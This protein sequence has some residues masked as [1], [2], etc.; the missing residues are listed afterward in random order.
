MRLENLTEKQKEIL[1]QLSP[2]SIAVKEIKEKIELIQNAREFTSEYKKEKINEVLEKQKAA[3]SKTLNEVIAGLESSIRV[4]HKWEEK[5]D[6]GMLY[7]MMMFK[8][9][10]GTGD[11]KRVCDLVANNP[12]NRTY[13]QLFD[14]NY[15]NMFSSAASSSNRE[16]ALALH[17]TR[18][19]LDNLGVDQEINYV[20]TNLQA[21]RD[22]HNL[23]NGLEIMD[24][25]V[26]RPVM[27]VNG[28]NI[29][30]VE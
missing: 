29:G 22:S 16:V 18:E 19:A 8:E 17:E 15:E 26:T 27:D 1:K 14:L 6:A 24:G 4:E 21:V 3:Y 2:C 7:D 10:L 28:V 12:T 5:S 20:L 30:K 23:Y 13:R 9:Y 11:I 25:I